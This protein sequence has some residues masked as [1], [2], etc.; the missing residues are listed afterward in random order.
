MAKTALLLDPVFKLHDTGPGH[1]ESV[2]RYLAIT[3]VL[4][5]AGVPEKCLKIDPRNATDSE[6]L[7]CHTAQYLNTVKKDISE[8]KK[9]LSTGDTNVCKESY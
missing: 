6:I 1:P 7:G 5:K 8:G 2:A 4:N 3:E 9:E